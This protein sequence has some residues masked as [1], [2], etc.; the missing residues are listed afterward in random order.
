MRLLFVISLFFIEITL[1][2]FRTYSFTI[3]LTGRLKRY[4][5]DT[6]TSIS[7][8]PVFVKYD[9][10]I[11]GKAISN[12]KGVFLLTWNDG[13]DGTF[14][15][16]CFYCV[17]NMNDTLLLA[18]IRRIGSETPDLTFQIPKYPRKF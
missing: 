7:H 9:T 12:K 3:D 15:P 13:N 11:I 6:L 4:P 1:A 16:F 18:K 8:I 5:G 10:K 14:K 17:I 2:N